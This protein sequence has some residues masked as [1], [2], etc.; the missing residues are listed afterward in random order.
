MFENKKKGNLIFGHYCCFI[1]PIHLVNVSTIIEMQQHLNKVNNRIHVKITC[2]VF[3]PSLNNKTT[4]TYVMM[5]TTQKDS[6]FLNN[7]FIN[8]IY[9]GMETG[10]FDSKSFW[11]ELKQWNFAKSLITSKNVCIWTRKTFWVFHSLSQ[12]CETIYRYIHRLK[13]FDN[14]INCNCCCC[15]Y[16]S[17]EQNCIETTC[18]WK[19]FVS[20]QPVTIGVCLP[21]DDAKEKISR[22]F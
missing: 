15:W 22:P 6:L 10:H 16:T 1:H 12:V 20:K 18:I 4:V 14:W 13:L 3:D 17:K 7:W 2:R 11:Y 5:Q 19:D 9:G 8:E 21:R